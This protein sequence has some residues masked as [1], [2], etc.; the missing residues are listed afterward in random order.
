MA[1]PLA[2]A[3]AVLLAGACHSLPDASPQPMGD[4]I[5]LG[6]AC[7]PPPVSTGILAGEVAPNIVGFDQ[8]GEEI[9]LYA[10]LCDKHVL[11]AKAGFD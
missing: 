11:V 4:P 1:R 5:E 3:P 8:F 2:L 6:D 7:D 10:D 9:D